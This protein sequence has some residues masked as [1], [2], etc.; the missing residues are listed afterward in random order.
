MGRLGNSLLELAEL[1]V[2]LQPWEQSDTENFLKSSLEAAGR[3]SPVFAQKAATRLHELTSGVPRRVSQLADLALVAGAGR[4]L[5][6]IDA[7]V[8]ESVYHELGVIEV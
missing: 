2:D 3:Q 8:V 5:D 4:Q 1:R 6:Q 7:D